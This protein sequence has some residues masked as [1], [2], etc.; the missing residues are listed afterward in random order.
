MD[1]GR[2]PRRKE[3]RQREPLT[4]VQA[5]LARGLH[6]P[7]KDHKPELQGLRLIRANVLHNSLI[8]LDEGRGEVSHHGGSVCRRF[9]PHKV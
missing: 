2:P 6:L 4:N 7:L 9:V 3:G 1:R 5:A 8:R